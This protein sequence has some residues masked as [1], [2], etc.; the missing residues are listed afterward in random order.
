MTGR[1]LVLAA[2]GSRREPAANALVRRLAESLRGRR[3]F[4]DG[5]VQQWDEVSSTLQLGRRTSAQLVAAFPDM[6][7]PRRFRVRVIQRLSETLQ[8]EAQYGR[9]SAFQMIRASASEQ[10]RVLVSITD[11]V[12]ERPFAT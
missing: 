5:R 7:D 12:S 11:T 1:A 3:L 4:D 8:L 9:L 6:A 2:H 10:S